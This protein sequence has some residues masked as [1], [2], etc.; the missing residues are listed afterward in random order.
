MKSSWPL[1]A[2]LI[3]GCTPSTEIV[4]GS[5]STAAINPEAPYLWG[6]KNF[7]KSIGLSNAL[8]SDEKISITEMG[9]AWTTSVSARSPFFSFSNLTN[10]SYNLERSDGVL[11]VY[12]VYDWNE[13]LT[14]NDIPSPIAITQIFCRR[15]NIGSSNEYCSIEHADILI[16]YDDFSFS[17]EINSA[18]KD[19]VEYDL[20]TVVLHE[21]GHFLGLSHIPEWIFR[22][23]SESA[24][25]KSNYKATS[26][27]YPSID[28]SEIK[29]VPKTK[30]TNALNSKYSISG[31]ASSAIAVESP[32]KPN[33]SDLGKNVKV[34]I[35][36]MPNGECH[37][38]MDGVS[39]GHHSIKLK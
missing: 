27:M 33:A 30:D 35:E 25:S 32:Y 17:T 3:A 16:N 10:N 28:F 36:L 11:G 34:V 23:S 8:S 4:E 37:H 26:V 39:I 7:P 38:K 24:I 6:N 29:R 19:P 14:P 1:L 18:D 20:R 2:L 9:D 5:S 22:P 15:Y 21:M 12:K 13:S 31:L